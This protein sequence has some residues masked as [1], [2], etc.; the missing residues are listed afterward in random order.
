MKV[1]IIV[2]TVM[3]LMSSYVYSQEE[4]YKE[5][6]YAEKMNHKLKRAMANIFISE[7]EIPRQ[8]KAAIDNRGVFLGHMEGLIKGVNITVARKLVGLCDLLT[9]PFPCDVYIF[10]PEIPNKEMIE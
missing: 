3:V 5:Q 1:V 6:T 2:L 8:M 7:L 9:M 10:D 4:T